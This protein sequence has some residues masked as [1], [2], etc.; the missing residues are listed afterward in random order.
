MTNGPAGALTVEAIVAVEPPR[1]PRLHPRERVVAYVAEAAGARQLFTL[2]LTGGVAVQLTAS[3]TNVSDPQWSPDGRRLVFVRGDEIW[4]VDRSGERLVRVDGHP[5]GVSHPRWSPDGLRI[6]FISRR[7]GWAQVWVVDAPVPRRGR[8]AKAP[9]RAE[10]RAITAAGS[11]VRQF[12]WSPDGTRIAIDVEGGPHPTTG[13]IRVVDVASG[14][15]E[16][17]SDPGAWS[18]GARWAADG[19]LFFVSDVDG[20][21][22]VLRRSPDGRTIA[23]VTSGEQEHGEPSGGVGWAPLPSPD[24]TRVVHAAIEDGL[25]RLIVATLAA[26]PAPRRRGRPPK[27]PRPE[28]AAGPAVRI[29][30]WDG[31]WRSVGW[32]AD[33]AW[34]VAIGESETRPQDLWLLPVPGVAAERARPRQITRSQPAVLGAAMAGPRV[35]VAERFVVDARDGTP[36]PGTLWRPPTATGKRGGT[37]VPAVVYAHGGPASQSFRG[38][39]PF[40]RLLVESGMAVVDVDFRG[41]TGYGRKYRHANRGEWG[42]ADTHDVVDVGRWVAGQPWSDG[43]LAVWGGSYGGY[44]VLCALVEEPSLW[45]AGVDLYGDSEIAESFRHGD[46]LGRMDIER[47]MGTPDDPDAA[48]L[49]RRGSPVYRAERIEAPLLL[50]HGRKD[51]RVVPLMTERMVEALTIEGKHHEVH[52]YE[53]E[54]HGW[55]A[56]ETRRDAFARILR[57]LQ[58]HLLD[59]VSPPADPAG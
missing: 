48:G 6:G 29:D 52:W 9:R 8:P 10:P 4:V 27:R 17:V 33:G 1:E 36:V 25:A 40:K 54:A 20:W 5:A 43:R 26:G 23:A 37:R 2:A 32:T 12:A 44:L 58:R 16:T 38:W 11:D 47:Q 57:F 55:E 53:E 24:A 13:L 15:E 18:A 59:E 41:S 49:Y 14:A 7:R 50:L 3:E 34:I 30:P 39:S 42:H 51:K 22:Q 28:A 56:R 45:R 19:S 21:F 35:P 46:R 31:V